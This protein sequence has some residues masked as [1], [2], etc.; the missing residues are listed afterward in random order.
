[1]NINDDIYSILQALWYEETKHNNAPSEL[2]L[3]FFYSFVFLK[4]LSLDIK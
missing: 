1:M 4:Y 3:S 2:S